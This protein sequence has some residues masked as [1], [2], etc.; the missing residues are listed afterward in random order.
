MLYA[1]GSRNFV[2]E[3]VTEERTSPRAHEVQVEGP[4]LVHYRL[5]GE[6]TARDLRELTVVERAL[7]EGN[8]RVHVLVD[9]REAKAISAG[10]VRAVPEVYRGAPVRVT[11]VFGASFALQVLANTIS[12]ALSALGKPPVLRFF[13]DETSARAWIEARRA[14]PGPISRARESSAGDHRPA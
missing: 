8:E 3:T 6:I 13:P 9:M 1:P 5:R 11:A 7:W 14:D 4:D 10:L 12:R 2:P